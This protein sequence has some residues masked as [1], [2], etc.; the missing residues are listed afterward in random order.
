VFGAAP[1]VLP[2][3]RETARAADPAEAHSA[4]S[5]APL[6]PFATADATPLTPEAS[7]T[8]VPPPSR[9][10]PTVPSP[11]ADPAP[12]PSPSPPRA[13]LASSAGGLSA[14]REFSASVRP[15]SSRIQALLADLMSARKEVTE[16]AAE[17]RRV[18]TERNSLR[19]RLAQ[20]ETKARELSSAF[21]AEAQL[22]S[23]FVDAHAA[24]SAALRARLAE[25]EAQLI[26]L[27]ELELRL[28]ELE[29]QLREQDEQLRQR[30]ERIRELT[31]RLTQ[32]DSKPPGERVGLRRIRGIGPAYER[33]LL[34]LGIT[35]I[36]QVAQLTAE[37]IARIAPLIKARADRI[38]RDDWVGQARRLA[39]D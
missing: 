6:P 33:A 7:V 11:G 5:F 10:T 3:S 17:L 31:A 29:S 14:R 12:A 28:V 27:P 22:R 16:R 24:S 2:H 23:E 9:A 19:A 8:E 15:E 26:A 1:S 34:A 36:S 20:A 18:V 32:P 13:E 30:D 35:R 38:E 37:D 21:R 4:E 39:D 25:L